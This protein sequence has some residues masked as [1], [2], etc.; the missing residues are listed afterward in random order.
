[1]MQSPTPV[2]QDLAHQLLDLGWTPFEAPA[3]PLRDFIVERQFINPTHEEN[4]DMQAWWDLMP[5]S[6]REPKTWVA[7][8][9]IHHSGRDPNQTGRAGLLGRFYHDTIEAPTAF[10][11]LAG[12]IEDR[13]TDESSRPVDEHNDLI[14]ILS[15]LLAAGHDSDEA[16]PITLNSTAKEG[17]K[18]V[19]MTM[20]DYLDLRGHWNA[21]GGPVKA[22]LAQWRLHQTLP[23]ETAK[24][25]AW[26]PRL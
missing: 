6:V 18:E 12:V 2:M 13:A 7:G 4:R 22:V 8:P 23:I 10:H 19:M 5:T 9:P 17:G 3:T 11:C 20:V 1:M 25:N 24:D 21:Y 14:Q 15:W 26:R 16:A